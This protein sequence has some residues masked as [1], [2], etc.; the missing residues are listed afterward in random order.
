M[1]TTF[2]GHRFRSR[3]SRLGGRRDAAS[4]VR[5]LLGCFPRAGRVVWIGVRPDR[6]QPLRPQTEV[7][8]HVGVGLQGD[9]YSR[10]GNGKRQVT[11]IQ[12]EH[13]AVIGALLAEPPIDPARLRRNL[14]VADVNLLALKDQVF[15]IG[16]AVLDGSG[17]AHPCSRM[18]EALGRG[19]YNAMRGHGGITARVI[20]GGLMRLGDSVT[21]INTAPLDASG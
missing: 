13:L 3:I 9:H 4:P 8:A 17:L 2:G 20:E 1:S 7:Q 21:W 19:G 18:E 5:A 11:L 12:A 10:R 6:R 15:R 14:V 16:G